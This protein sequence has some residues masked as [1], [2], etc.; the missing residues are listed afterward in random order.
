[1]KLKKG[2]SGTPQ[3][4]EISAEQLAKHI[5]IFAV[6][7]KTGMTIT[8]IQKIFGDGLHINKDA[9]SELVGKGYDPYVYGDCWGRSTGSM[10][11]HMMGDD[12]DSE[13]QI[14]QIPDG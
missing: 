1:M 14:Q 11:I 5:G 3:D 13:L 4:W 2:T 10:R 6:D 7:T 8:C 9:F 12:H